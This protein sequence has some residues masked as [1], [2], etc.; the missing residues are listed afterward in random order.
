[1]RGH[2]RDLRARIEA[3]AEIDKDVEITAMYSLLDVQARKGILPR[4]R[5][6][7]M[8]SRLTALINGR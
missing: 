2:I 8:K 5:A 7:R 4:K 1:M 3:G 6:S